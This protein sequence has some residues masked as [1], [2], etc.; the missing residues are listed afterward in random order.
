MAAYRILDTWDDFLRFWARCRSLPVAEQ[1]E[2]WRADYMARYPDLLRKQVEDYEAQGANWKA[3]A[4]E[5]ILPYLPERLLLMQEARDN[6]LQVCGPI[7]ERA[8]AALGL[9]F[10]V[11]FVI[12]VGIG[13]G[14]GWATRYEGAPACLLGLENIAEE[15]WHTP[16]RLRGLVAHELGHLAHMAWRGEWEAFEARERDPLCLLYSEGF[17]VW[18]EEVILG[19]AGHLAQ[20]A[21]W[22]AW[23]SAHRAALAAEF[24]RRADGGGDAR[25]FF[26]SWHE[27]QERSQ[28]GYYLGRE[29]IASLERGRTLREVACMPWERVA[30][31]ARAFLTGYIHE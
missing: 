23:C 15:R 11:A 7:H 5:Q 17:A 4:V 21:D 8:V 20:D 31:A 1:A 10:D 14:A 30:E 26:G 16:E 18:C 22:L 19:G 13:C 6:L 2:R 3:I 24:L 29:F 25:D 28:T 12:Y 9:D 27:I